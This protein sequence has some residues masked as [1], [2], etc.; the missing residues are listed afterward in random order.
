MKLHKNH[1]TG[2]FITGFIVL[3]WI[4]LLPWQTAQLRHRALERTAVIGS[5]A[6]SS[7]SELPSTHSEPLQLWANSVGAAD[8]SIAYM[9]V[10]N[11]KNIIRL[12]GQDGSLDNIIFSKIRENFII[13]GK[14]PSLYARSQN[15]LDYNGHYLVRE[16]KNG[17]EVFYAQ[18]GFK[19]DI[20]FKAINIFHIFY[21]IVTCLLLGAVLYYVYTI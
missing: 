17:D 21:L 14:Q 20:L 15:L 10:V 4:A 6:E 1:I 19:T 8:A 13:N 7:F 2:L 12:A 5:F 16:L 9:I 11:D 3:L 18:I